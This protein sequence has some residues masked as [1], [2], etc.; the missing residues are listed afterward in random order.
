MSHNALNISSFFIAKGVSPLKLQKLLY[1]SQ[2]WYFERRGERLFN[3][4]IRAWIYG[5]VVSDVW[6]HFKWMKRSS[7][8][9]TGRAPIPV[10]LTSTQQYHL[11]QVWEAY[12]H[13]SGS[14]LVDLTHNETPWKVSRKGLLTDQPSQRAV[15][16]DKNT[17]KD[18]HLVN[19]VIP[20]VSHDL[21]ARGGYANS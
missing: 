20:R 19:G 17:T 13:L 14:E 12:G 5:P 10:L 21:V 3:D 7:Q 1:Y 8:I 16:I 11:D 9:P 15:I 6:H 18:F 2:L 4:E